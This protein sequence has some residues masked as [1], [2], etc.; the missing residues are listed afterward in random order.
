MVK[1]VHLPGSQNTEADALSRMSAN[2][3]SYSLSQAVF[4]SI[5]VS[6]S[7]PLSVDCFASR[8]TYK[9]PVYYSWQFD[10]LSSLVNAFTCRWRDGCY[11]FPPL[12]MTIYEGGDLLP[13][14][15]Q[16]YIQIEK[17]KTEDHLIGGNFGLPR[18]VVQLS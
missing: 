14:N 15:I 12:P 2:D 6:L 7:F 17:I 4:D 11:L 1:A 3:H 13:T 9:L 5:H 10:P 16:N 8:L 18:R